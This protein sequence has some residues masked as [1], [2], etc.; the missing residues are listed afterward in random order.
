MNK[1]NI[2]IGLLVGVV[3]LFPL[4][5]LLINFKGAENGRAFYK[6][7]KNNLGILPA[8]QLKNWAN[9]SVLSNKIKGNVLIM[10]FINI[11]N[12]QAVLDVIKPVVKTGQ[13][14]EEVDNLQFLTFDIANDS[15][16]SKQYSDN[17]TPQ[18]RKMWQILRGGNDVP[19]KMKLPDLYHIALV[20]TAGIIR[21]FY[22]VRNE[23]DKRLLV[24]HIA[25]MPIKRKY[26]VEKKDQKQL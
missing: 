10:S 25:I 19:S 9:D 2:Q 15:I 4:I 14:R 18:D 1:K 22:D 23:T 21:R 17:F 12:R 16:F 26:S 11:E 20:D 7:I 6:E 5:S 8:F 24:E 3:V 13:F